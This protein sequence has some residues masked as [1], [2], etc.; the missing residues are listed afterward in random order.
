[1]CC[2]LPFWLSQCKEPTKEEF[3]SAEIAGIPLYSQ[4]DPDSTWVGFIPYRKKFLILNKD[5]D[6]GKWKQVE[7]LSQKGFIQNKGYTK[8]IP[9]SFLFVD[10]LEGVDLFSKPG[11][12]DSQIAHLPHRSKLE[13]EATLDLDL[14]QKGF[15]EQLPEGISK[16]E[17]VGKEGFW[18]Y[19]KYEDKKGYLRYTEKLKFT[20][21]AHFFVVVD[22]GGIALRSNPDIKSQSIEFLPAGTI[23]EILE[24][25]GESVYVKKTKGFWFKTEFKG[26]KGWVFSGFTVTSAERNYLED[27]KYIQNDE[28]FLHYMESAIELERFDFREEDI[29]NY[30]TNTILK[31]NYTIYLID[32][33]FPEE[34]CTVATKSRII[35]KNNKTGSSHSLQGV[36]S[37]IMK[38]TDKPLEDTLYSEYNGCN[39]CCP[40]TGNILYFLLED[41][42]FYIPFKL[43]NST[44]FCSYGPVDGIELARENRYS[45]LDKTILMELKLPVCKEP[46]S[47]E[48]F[49]SEP[50]DYPHTLFSIVRVKQREVSIERYFDKGI[51]EQFR[52]IWNK[53]SK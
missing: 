52:E 5:K 16:E 9:S 29:K 31:K 20:P 4:A 13:I 45:V 27:K 38:A 35:F 32:Y 36:Y 10:D 14:L 50:I 24:T 15:H 53:S 48:I 26:K 17:L 23:G 18:L 33:G 19:V 7:F 30:K 44:G 39:C 6:T 8:E 51:P 49:R 42:V 2:F 21:R 28:W 34:D 43:S 46:E 37:E 11:S 1:L 41:K 25:T 22:S 12:F 3:Y 40:D 47:P